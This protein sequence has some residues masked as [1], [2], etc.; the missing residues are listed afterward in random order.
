MI[1][2]KIIA[3]STRPD[4][5]NIQPSRW[6]YELAKKRGDIQVELLDLV[7]YNLPL[8]DEPMPPMHRKYTKAHTKKWSEAI[9]QADGYILVSPEYNHSTSAALKNA[10]DY[11]YQEWNFKPVS[12][13]SYGSA[14]GGSRAVE[15]LR[16]I[17]AE[18]KMYDIREQVMLPNY[19]EHTDENGNYDFTESQEKLAC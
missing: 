15:H 1:T 16:T 17:S 4:R 7:E 13:V 5:F 3:G 19:W 9:E 8:L 14:A 11:L 2:I 10:I 12:F 6:I 18:L